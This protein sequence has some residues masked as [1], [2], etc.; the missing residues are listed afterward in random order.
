MPDA[1]RRGF[2]VTLAAPRQVVVTEYEGPVLAANHV[3]LKTLYSGISAGT[4]LA[5]YRG[6]SPFLMKR[7]DS[8]RR[9]FLSGE[10]PL[11]YPLSNWG[12]E[13]VGEVVELGAAVARV[14]LGDV[15]WGTWGHKSSQL[16]DEDWA[17][18]RS[19]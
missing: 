13:E 12:Y 1:N 15:I 17:A 3:R 5:A 6:S 19:G 16:A 11:S 8:D 18:A 14:K 10:A 9:L 7:W 4:E 2:A